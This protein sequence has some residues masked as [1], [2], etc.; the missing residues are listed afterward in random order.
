MIQLFPS[1]ASRKAHPRFHHFF[2]PHSLTRTWSE[3]R[4]SP[5]A[6]RQFFSLL[7]TL[8]AYSRIISWERDNWLNARGR[9]LVYRIEDTQQHGA[10]TGRKE[11]VGGTQQ[12]KPAAAGSLAD[13][14][15]SNILSLP[16]GLSDRVVCLQLTVSSNCRPRSHQAL[17][18][19]WRLINLHTPGITGASASKIRRATKN[20]KNIYVLG[21]THNCDCDDLA[22][23]DSLRPVLLFCAF[24]N[25]ELFF[26]II[27]R[28]FMRLRRR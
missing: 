10:R 19:T 24:A 12:K 25:S 28:H 7:P 18:A 23:N 3:L 4:H 9:G 26:D 1:C 20:I 16:M 15:G 22:Y 8:S 5:A 6:V 17:S 27:I 14:S 11:A 2:C 21:T 13:G